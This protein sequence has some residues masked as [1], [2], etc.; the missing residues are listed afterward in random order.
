M[1]MKEIVNKAVPEKAKVKAFFK[2]AAMW[3]G[4]GVVAFSSCKAPQQTTA[5]VKADLSNYEI[6]V[7]M[8]G[9]ST[10]EQKSVTGVSINNT[11]KENNDKTYY[12][13]PP[14]ADA[15]TL[16]GDKNLSA[17]KNAATLEYGVGGIGLFGK[18]DSVNIGMV[19]S[20][21][22]MEFLSNALV[23]N[24]S[25]G[26]VRLIDY[27]KKS[28]FVKTHAGYATDKDYV[29][30][31]T[32]YGFAGIWEGATDLPYAMWVLPENK[33]TYSVK[34]PFGVTPVE[35]AG[36]KLDSTT[37]TYASGGRRQIELAINGGMPFKPAAEVKDYKYVKKPTGAFSYSDRQNIV[38]T[39]TNAVYVADTV[40]RYATGD[41]TFSKARGDTAIS[42]G[43]VALEPSK[44][45]SALGKPGEAGMGVVITRT[46]VLA[47]Y[48]RLIQSDVSDTAK[49]S[50]V[51][52]A[53]VTKFVPG[54]QV[55]ENCNKANKGTE[56]FEPVVGDG[57][58]MYSFLTNVPG[59]KDTM[60]LYIQRKGD[61]DIITL[62]MGMAGV[63][64]ITHTKLKNGDVAI[65]VIGAD[66][67]RV[68]GCIIADGVPYEPLRT[69]NKILEDKD[70]GFAPMKNQ[71]NEMLYSDNQAQNKFRSRFASRNI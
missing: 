31:R 70:M 45:T 48:Y 32:K 34:V 6:K 9:S 60:Q 14:K 41:T 54:L 13:V 50:A 4:A 35:D 21:Q 61:G 20:K 19:V 40:M 69:K 42:F 67:K 24:V 12:Y 16:Y 44:I 15:N 59:E 64:A 28:L 65:D 23:T 22:V 39:T 26:Y 10:T 33:K 38:Y 55:I 58:G 5:P 18:N 37:F 36:F 2:K 52:N 30:G 49:S 51:V 71:Y 57:Y 68:D 1:K 17:T 8:G 62:K 53:P 27:E 63:S 47:T 43:T 46:G 25:G 66:G 11:G 3:T 56:V 29:I 7:G